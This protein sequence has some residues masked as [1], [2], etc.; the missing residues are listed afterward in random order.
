MFALAPPGGLRQVALDLCQALASGTAEQ[1]RS[2][3]FTA[4]RAPDFKL[5]TFMEL[6]RLQGRDLPLFIARCEFDAS[7]NSSTFG[8]LDPCCCPRRSGD[9]R[10][11][12]NKPVDPQPDPAV[13]PPRL[14]AGL[15]AFPVGI[16]HPW[17]S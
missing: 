14:G 10:G 5:R 11:G 8:P 17:R 12:A 6:K 9:E 7:P 2:I 15:F 13:E 3:A 16:Q 1:V 4:R